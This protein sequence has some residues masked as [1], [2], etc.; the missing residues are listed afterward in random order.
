[1][2][3]I[4]TKNLEILDGEDTAHAKLEIELIGRL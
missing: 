2:C 4:L 1:M 3:E